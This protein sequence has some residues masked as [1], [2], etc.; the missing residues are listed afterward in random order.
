M[1]KK[2][3]LIGINYENTS[4]KLFGCGNDVKNVRSFL[5][6]NGYLPEDIEVLTDSPATES[7]VGVAVKSPTRANIL[8]SIFALITSGAEYLY[9]HYSGHGGQTADLSGDEED[10]RDETIIP[11]DFRAAGVIVDDELRALAVHLRDHQRMFCVFDSCHSGTVLDLKYKLVKE[12]GVGLKMVP[13]RNYPETRGQCVMLSG[14]LDNQS[15]ADAF[16]AGE[17]QGAL[18]AALLAVVKAVPKAELT[19][20]K[21]IEEVR[22][23]LKEK[24]YPQFPLLTSG[25]ELVLSRRVVL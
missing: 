13:D 4:Q 25:R 19:Y 18:T 1:M 5:V 7:E 14:C 11:V 15:S 24:N 2:A 22:K 6:E 16:E 21:L 3:L 17:A 12:Y 9:L 8:S 23:L 20:E 10:G